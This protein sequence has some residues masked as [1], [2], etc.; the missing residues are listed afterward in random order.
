MTI[1]S[2]TSGATI[3]YTTDGSV[4][5]ETNG[6]VYSGT[7]VAINITTTLQA[8]AY[9]VGMADSSVASGTYTLNLPKAAT[10]TF[11]PGAGTYT[12]AQ[13]VAISTSTSGATIRYTTDGS[14]PTETN[15]TVYS[16]TKVAIDVT[17]TLKAIAYKV[18]NADSSVASGTYTLNLPKAATPTFSPAANTYTAAQSVAI[19]TSTSGATIRYTT[20]G[21]TPTET[22][23]TVYSGTK[24]ARD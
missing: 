15:G 7:K 22:H 14:S 12:A 5:T 17:T 11:S 19:S 8:I 6:T 2:T 3:R 23:G 21:S 9:K 13:S 24:V 4:P 18:G 1:T 16:G 10:P 20:D